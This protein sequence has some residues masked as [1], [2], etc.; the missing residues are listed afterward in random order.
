MIMI[1]NNKHNNN[2]NNDEKKKKKHSKN[3]IKE[4]PR[5]QLFACFRFFFFFVERAALLWPLVQEYNHF[6]LLKDHCR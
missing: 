3:Q 5:K 1:D 4:I 6:R 2:N